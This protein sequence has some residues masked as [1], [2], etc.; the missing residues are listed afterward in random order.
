MCSMLLS[1]VISPWSYPI[2]QIYFFLMPINPNMETQPR[3]LS[4]TPD[5]CIQLSSW[6]LP[7]LDTHHLQ[8]LSH[9]HPTSLTCSFSILSVLVYSTMLHQ[10]AEA[11]SGTPLWHLLLY[12]PAHPITSNSCPFYS[13]NVHYLWTSLWIP[14]VFICYCSCNKLPRA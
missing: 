14:T 6:I 2:A 8:N 3:P 13:P 5:L 7:T 10:I 1:K 12:H 4:W 9:N 11:N